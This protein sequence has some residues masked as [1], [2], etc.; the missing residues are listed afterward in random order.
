MFASMLGFILAFF[1]AGFIGTIILA[2]LAFS[3]KDSGGV[4]VK[5]KSVVEIKLDE[6]IVERG[7]D[8]PVDFDFG[9]LRPSHSIG[10]DEIKKYIDKAAG[11]DHVKGIFL[12]LS[13][14]NAG[15]ATLEEI[16]HALVEFK[17]SDKFIYAY[18][19]YYSQASYYLASVADKIYIHPQGGMDFHG[20]SAK[21]VFLKGALEKLEIEPIVI[22]HGKFKSAVE[23]FILDRMS[24]ENKEQTRSFVGAIWKTYLENIAKS[25]KMTVAGLDSLSDHMLIQTPEDA[26]AYKL[27][28][29]TAYYDEVLSDLKKASGLK[30]K[31]KERLVSLKKYVK[32]SV[33]SGTSKEKIAVIYAVGEI[34]GGEGSDE[35]IGSERISKAIRKARLD[36]SIKAIVLRVNSP[37]GSALASDVIWRETV[38][39][40][41]DKPFVVSMGDVAASGGYYISCAADSIV[42]EPNTIT[43]SIGVF[44]LLFN[45]QKLFNNKLG[46]T[47]DTVK[48]GRYADIGSTT[49]PMTADEREIIQKQVERIYDRFTGIVA[50]GRKIDKAYV[51]SIGQGRVWSGIDALRLGL[52]DKLGGLED[53]IAVAAKMAKLDNYRTVSLPE[54]KPFFEKLM[55]DIS[56]ES[57]VSVIQAELGENYKYYRELKSIMNMQGVQAR[58]PYRL[59]IY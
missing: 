42:A 29:K 26:V 50:D 40:K 53:A 34:G 3:L 23:P 43:G 21:A 49:R 11:D 54:Q 57:S 27:A 19:D 1:I 13:D 9:T 48:T 20:L 44:G 6:D 10:L 18:S 35:T 46:I 38:L 39:A 55:E 5:D 31:D 37:G 56:A 45:S 2:G 24:P 36:S 22:R 4:E 12:N 41:K 28:D 17:S 59:E 7:K 15:I 52:V 14:V 25:R 51:D 47:F 8:D 58:M 16:R 33:S 32:T 30:E